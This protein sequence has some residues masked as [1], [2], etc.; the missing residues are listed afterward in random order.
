MAAV[1][2]QMKNENHDARPAFGSH[3]GPPL[4]S[5]PFANEA[6]VDAAQAVAAARAAIS[7]SGAAPERYEFH[8][9]QVQHGWWVAAPE[10]AAGTG[11]GWLIDLDTTARVINVSRTPS[12]DE[13]G[14]GS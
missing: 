2:P 13:I 6:V 8:P 5:R 4:A 9:Q 14:Q 12:L 1:T 11:R 10:R 7:A 3:R